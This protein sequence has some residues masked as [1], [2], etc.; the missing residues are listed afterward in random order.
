MLYK[1]EVL[2]LHFLFPSG[3]VCD[4]VL[5]LRVLWG[6][7]VIWCHLKPYLNA[8]Y[9]SSLCRY[10]N[11]LPWL[12]PVKFYFYF[13]PNTNKLLQLRINGANKYWISRDEMNSQMP[14]NMFERFLSTWFHAQHLACTH[15]LIFANLRSG[16]STLFCL[17]VFGFL[18]SP[19]DF[20]FIVFRERVVGRET[21]R[22]TDIDW[23]PSHTPPTEVD[24]ST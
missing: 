14:T 4:Y 20:L 6:R 12:F 5:C 18:S 11:N 3:G 8:F 19:E 7:I 16:I 10:F 22:Q 21:E 13:F 9:I 17:C 24:T 2:L 23:P 15:Y 1:G